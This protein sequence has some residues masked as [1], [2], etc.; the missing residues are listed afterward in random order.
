MEKVS[1]EMIGTVTVLPGDAVR[2]C[3]EREFASA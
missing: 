1:G 3:A 2:A